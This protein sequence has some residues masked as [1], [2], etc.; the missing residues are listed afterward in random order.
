[1][2]QR[3]Q[4]GRA[5]QHCSFPRRLLG[6]DADSSLLQPPA[7]IASLCLQLQIVQ[8]DLLYPLCALPIVDEDYTDEVHPEL[9]HWGFPHA[10]VYGFG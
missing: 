2:D 1:M 7:T 9:R 3:Q 6:V 5:G 4:R 10:G 8:W